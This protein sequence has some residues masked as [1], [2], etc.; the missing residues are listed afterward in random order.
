MVLALTMVFLATPLPGALVIARVALL[1]ASVLLLGIWGWR[2]QR[3]GRNGAGS[4]VLV[5]I[6][7]NNKTI[8]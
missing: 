8:K 7:A 6:L 3:P 4:S 5:P 2:R 1:V